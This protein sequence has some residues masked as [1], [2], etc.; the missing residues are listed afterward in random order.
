MGRVRRL[1]GQDG[2][3]LVEILVV[4]LILAALAAI[5][6]PAFLSQK[7][8]A[9]DAAAKSD[10][11]NAETAMNVYR[12]E[13]DGSFACG[14]ND[15]CVAKLR[16]IEANIPATGLSVS[17]HDGMGVAGFDAFRVTALGA[18]ARTFW[19]ARD[20]SARQRGCA[21]NGAPKPG[22]CRVPDGAPEGEW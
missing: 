14:T 3:T 13:H 19:I 11:R 18:E 16:L 21:L 5:A 4:I 7:D 8:K 1:R 2:F 10:A 12:T 22:G 6:L 15:A 20:G 9:S 17:G